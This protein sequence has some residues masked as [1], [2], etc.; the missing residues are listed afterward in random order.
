MSANYAMALYMDA[1]ATLED[2]REA[3]TTLEDTERIARRVL[4]GAHPNTTGI[5]RALRLARA[6]LH[7]REAEAMR[8]AERDTSAMRRDLDALQ[9]RLVLLAVRKSPAVQMAEVEALQR[10]FH[11]LE[12]RFEAREARTVDSD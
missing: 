2:L 6:A 7:A 10:D 3:V 5:E 1:S 8:A 4:G 12:R 9:R 11:A